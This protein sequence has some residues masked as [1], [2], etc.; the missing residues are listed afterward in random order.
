MPAEVH[1]FLCLS[2]NFGVLVHD[3]KTG[4]TAAIDVPDAAPYLAAL[5]EKDWTLT[6]ILITHRHGDHIDGVPALREKFPDAKLY[7]PA[8]EADR[9]I[10][11]TGPAHAQVREGDFV[12]VGSLAAKV[13]ETP[14][15]TAG[16]IVYH[17]PEENLLFAGDTLFSLGCGRVFETTMT[18][19][20]ES[21]VKLAS[22]PGETRLYCGHEY[23]QAN[24]RFALSVDGGNSLLQ[25]RMRDVDAKR[26]EGVFTLPTTIELELATNPFLRAENPDV[27]GN[28]GL[29]GAD[30]AAVFAELRERKN[31][32]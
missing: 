1:Q 17:F 26:A 2:D 11:V 32:A 3:P 23:T 19:M 13:I 10:A 7:V 31:K 27:Q 20:W 5:A 28:V 6:D 12:K 22:L 18:V 21:L 29:K 15:H 16:H 14:G 24:G 30:P 25:D 4:A 9:I 8:N